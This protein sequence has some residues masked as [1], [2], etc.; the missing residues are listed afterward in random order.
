MKLVFQKYMEFEM[1]TGNK[2][3]IEKLKARVE[4]YLE[5][6]FT[7]QDAGA[8]D[9]DSDEDVDMQWLIESLVRKD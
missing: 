9:N 8:K 5:K 2:K 1:Q 7:T 3:N 6:A 4:E